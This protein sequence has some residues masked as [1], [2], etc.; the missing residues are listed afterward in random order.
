[1]KKEGHYLGAHSD[2]HLLYNDWIKRDKLLVSKLDFNADISE[3]Y[4]EMAEFGILKTDAKYFLPPFEWYNS[5][6]SKWTNEQELKIINFTHGTR[7][8]ADYTYPEMGDKYVDS[9]QIYASVLKQEAHGENGLNGFI[10]LVHLGSDARRTDKFYHKLPTLIHT[11]KSKG[12][13]FIR[14]DTLLD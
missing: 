6:I 3:N 4:R 10:L 8:N 11:L 14:I 5:T 2:K 13:N 1:M 9:D 7:S 12:Y